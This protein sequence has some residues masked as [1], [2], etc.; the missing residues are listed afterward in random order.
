MTTGFYGDL[1]NLLFYVAVLG[2]QQ[3]CGKTKQNI[4]Y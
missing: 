2:Q 3:L 1:Q 4:I